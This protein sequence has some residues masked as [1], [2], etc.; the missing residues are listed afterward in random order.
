MIDYLFEV[1]YSNL[2]SSLQ[3]L[4]API[5]NHDNYAIGGI[6]IDSYL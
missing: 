2:L 3:K 4:Q 5:T 1:E 6:F